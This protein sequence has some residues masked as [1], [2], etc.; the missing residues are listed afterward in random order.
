MKRDELR[1]AWGLRREAELGNERGKEAIERALTYGLEAAPSIRDR[2]ISLF[3]RG[4]SPAFAGINTFL[5]APYLEDANKVGGQDV[6]VVGAPLD[7]G[8]TIRPGAR[9]GPRGLRQAS[10][11]PGG[12]NLEAG[13]DLGECLTIAD[14]GDVFTIPANLEK[15]FD[16][17]DRAIGHIFSRG[18][19]PLV[20]GGDHSIG[21]PD[22]RGIAPY[23][24]GNI[25]IIHFDRH[26]DTAETNLDERMH[27]TPWFH[28][29]NIPNAPATNLVQIGIGGWLGTRPGTRVCRERGTTVMTMDDVDRLGVDKVAEIALEVA[30][31]NAKAV[32]LSFDI[33]CVDP[34]FAPGTGTPEPGGF[35]PREVLRLLRQVAR[36]G[37]T[38]MEVVEV[39]PPYDVAEITA[40]LGVRA[41]LDVL[42]T[43][44][45]EGKLGR[46]PVPAPQSDQSGPSEQAGGDA[47]G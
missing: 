1:G 41:A 35:L 9:Y 32:W 26:V 6:V 21:Y 42:G 23:I 17:I 3:S 33:D 14:I 40:L 44:V 38:G 18:V 8:A 11:I 22:I 20:L 28:A 27:G 5:W 29:T 15:S 36:E 7:S 13:V 24:D 19:F 31:K 46:R 10:A 30:W 45:S 12:Y 47:G 2:T 39:A 37:V 25:G 34:A 16:Q 4:R 43:L